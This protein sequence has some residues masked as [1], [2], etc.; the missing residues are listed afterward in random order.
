[1]FY[2]SFLLL[3]ALFVLCGSLSAASVEENIKAMTKKEKAAQLLIVG[4]STKQGMIDVL[5]EYKVGGIILFA[6]NIDN[7]AHVKELIRQLQEVSMAVTGTPLIVSVD[8]E[9][10][11]VDRL[12]GTD[13]MPFSRP[14]I[15]WGDKYRGDPKGA[16]E[17]I[18]TQALSTAKELKSMGFNVNFAP[19]LDV[20]DIDNNA[21]FVKS[22][23]S[24][25]ADPEAVG[26]LGSH[27]I[28]VLQSQGIS[29]TAK[30]F[31]GHGSTVADTHLGF[32]DDPSTME[33]IESNHLVPFK[34]AIEVGVDCIMISH[35]TYKAIDPDRP[36]TLSPAIAKGLLRDK[37][38]YK[39][40]I[41]S[42]SLTMGAIRS[43]FGT[44]A[45]SMCVNSGIDTLIIAHPTKEDIDEAV[46]EIVKNVDDKRL[47]EAVAQVIR[48][49]KRFRL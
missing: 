1:M 35:V 3:M 46:N 27:Y 12:A 43:N 2:R 47:D 26:R 17:G 5:R 36:A 13:A 34:A 8:E 49:K 25:G 32:S 6:S 45:Y 7:R 41:V 4:F 33:R 40:M 20:C 11:R 21:L 30:H 48:L 44:E 39:G 19:V 15:E 22:G 9:G 31:P 23:R 24:Y 42:D 18:Y 29:A 38:G 14:N 28:K 10:G 37:L 16:L